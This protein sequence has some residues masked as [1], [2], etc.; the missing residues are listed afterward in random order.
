[1][2]K[3]YLALALT[4]TCVAVLFR[5]VLEQRMLLHMLIHIPLLVGAGV[6]FAHVRPRPI[7]RVSGFSSWNNQGVAGW[8]LVT[9]IITAW[10]IPRALDSAVESPSIDALKV[11][12]LLFAGVIGTSSWR[13]ASNAVARVFFAGNT[14]WMTATLGMLLRDAPTRLCTSYGARD[15]QETGVALIAFSAALG[16][17]A[18]L[19]GLLYSAETLDACESEPSPPPHSH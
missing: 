5:D 13:A 14:L 11:C 2:S 16:A 15:Q 4:L 7:S 1:M 17:A 19:Y 8:I 3:T 6:L 10:M 18:V 12:L 9:G